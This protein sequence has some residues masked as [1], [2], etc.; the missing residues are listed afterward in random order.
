V[1][2]ARKAKLIPGG[3][4][5]KGK[6]KKETIA[7]RQVGT[8][9]EEKQKE[10]IV[11]PRVF[12]W[13][14]GGEFSEGNRKKKTTGVNLSSGTRPSRRRGFCIQR[15]MGRKTL[16]LI[17]NENQKEHDRQNRKGRKAPR[18]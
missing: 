9:R 1:G 3:G 12:G 4:G 17:D 6:R 16:K 13:G 10:A 5:P 7:A 8:T 15:P 14:G 18:F 11:E 2:Y